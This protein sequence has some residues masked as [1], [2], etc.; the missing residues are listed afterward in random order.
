ME[1]H[2]R[3]VLYYKSK[4]YVVS[5]IGAEITNAQEHRTIITL[6]HTFKVVIGEI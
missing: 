4:A 2:T 1:A 6:F 3:L 5:C